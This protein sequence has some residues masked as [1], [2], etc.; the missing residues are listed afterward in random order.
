MKETFDIAVVGAGPAGL[1]A[2]VAAAA[3]NDTKVI[4]LEKM[5]KPARKLRITGKGRCNITNINPEDEFLKNIFPDSRFFRPSF[6][7]FSN[8]DLVSFL[9]AAGLDTIEERGGRV[10]PASQKSWDV[11]GVLMKEAERKAA[12]ICRAK[13]S[14][15]ITERNAVTGLCYEHRGK[16]TSISARA[17]ILATGGLSYPLTGSTGDGYEFARR[18]GH[19]IVMLRPSLTGLELDGYSTVNAA[20]KNIELSLSVDGGVVQKEFGEMEFV[21][22]GITGP[23]VL[24]VSR[25]A[26]DAIMGGKKVSVQINF[27]PA[28]SLQ[29]LTGRIE[30]EIASLSDGCISDLLRKLLPAPLVMPFIGK[31]R[32][33]GHKKLTDFNRADMDK[34]VSGLFSFKYPV[35]GFRPFDEAIVTAGGISLR[36]INP[37]TMCSKLIDNLF[38]AGEIIDLDANT[39]GY[40]LQIAFSTGFLAGRSAAALMVN[41]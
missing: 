15:L 35:S 25:N 13:V 24:K 20:L 40:N 39:G 26:V 33:A 7:R 22:Y 4:L 5:E 2:T 27:K 12:V 41:G 6:R 34:T 17:V 31:I 19:D 36:E 1:M 3:G 11:A 21:E 23:A 29:Q 9:N 38:F 8:T 14:K 28:L 18:A 37:K 30:R 32:I 16:Q 10:F